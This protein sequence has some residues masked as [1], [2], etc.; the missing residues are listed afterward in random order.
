MN[1]NLQDMT[2]QALSALDEA[3]ERAANWAPL[4]RE[5]PG[6]FR[7]AVRSARPA[8][9]AATAYLLSGLEKMGVYERVISPGDK[10]EGASWVRSMHRGNEQYHDPAL[11]ERKPPA[12]PPDKPWPEPALL[13]CVNQYARAALQGFGERIDEPVPPPP[14]GWPQL[15]D[16]PEAAVEWIK[17]RPYDK[18]AWGACS[19]GARMASRLL[20]WHKRGHI[21]LDPLIEALRFFYSIQD[22]E[23][24]LWGAPDQPRNVRINGAFKLFPLMR[25]TLDLPVPHA[26]KLLDS[27]LAEF[28]RPDYDDTACGCDELDNWYVIALIRPFVPEHRDMEILRTA[29]R[30][31]CRTLEVFSK[32]D[33][34][35]SFLPRTCGMD[36]IGV[37]MA[38]GLAQGDCMGAGIFGRG[39][40]I[41][42]DL[43]GLR[44]RTSWTGEWRI[45][46]KEPEE[47]LARAR[48]ALLD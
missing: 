2:D 44:G 22:A 24:G 21:P 32:P 4:V 23:T 1:A 28:S 43:L 37:D 38:P 17:A 9:V 12:W 27:V 34:G 8:N 40:N 19:H 42:V 46:E 29:A 5:A 14:P 18:N 36:W 39:I 7:W 26:D 3:A 30:R 15:E 35:L 47:L 25:E 33:G 16:G 48:R 41:C 20:D 10:Q 6:R 11:L 45:R 31:I 13:E